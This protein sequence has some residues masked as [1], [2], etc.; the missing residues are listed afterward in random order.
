MAEGTTRLGGVL[1]SADVRSTIEAVRTLGAHVELAEQPDGSLAGSVRGWGSTCP[2][3]WEPVVDCGNSGT[4]ARLLMG[5]LAGWPIK[6]TLTGDE[7]LSR[8][9]MRR[10]TGPLASNT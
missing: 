4:T 3:A 10:I 6:V 1:D 7:S 9:P 8:R 2:A 5:V